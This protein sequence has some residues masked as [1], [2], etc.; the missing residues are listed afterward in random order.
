[1]IF[2]EWKIISMLIFL[3]K[4]KFVNNLDYLSVFLNEKMGVIYVVFCIVVV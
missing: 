1:M 4:K 2:F 3:G